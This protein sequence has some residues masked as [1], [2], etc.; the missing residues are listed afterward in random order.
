[1]NSGRFEDGDDYKALHQML[2]FEKVS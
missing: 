1:M 2:A